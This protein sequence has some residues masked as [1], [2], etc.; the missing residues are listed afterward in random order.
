[1]KPII[2]LLLSKVLS[3]PPSANKPAQ[4]RYKTLY[5]S[6]KYLMTKS[7]LAR[8]DGTYLKLI[9]KLS[10]QNLLILDDFGLYALEQQQA[11]V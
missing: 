3:G 10:K 9:A 11:L 4:W 2:H 6:N 1:M 8:A 7:T 5:I